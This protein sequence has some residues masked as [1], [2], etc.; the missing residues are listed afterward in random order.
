MKTEHE[1][2]SNERK[3]ELLR[4]T[5]VNEVGGAE[6]VD[7]KRFEVG[8]LHGEYT[9]KEGDLLIHFFWREPPI[10]GSPPMRIVAGG[11]PAQDVY[12]PWPHN[13]REYMREAALAA[14]HLHDEPRRLEI[15]W[16]GELASW[17]MLVKGVAAIITPPKEKLVEMSNNILELI[18]Q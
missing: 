15:D 17:C 14:F 1:Q 11:F 13:F 2:N 8:Y 7:L 5:G 3:V 18:K 16:I 4:K 9:G 6:A 12:A 10:Q